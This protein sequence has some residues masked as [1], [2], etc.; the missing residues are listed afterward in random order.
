MKLF[1]YFNYSKIVFIAYLCGMDAAQ[2][3]RRKN[4]FILLRKQNV[5]F[6]VVIFQLMSKLNSP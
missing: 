1:K 4:V 2:R 6:K 3:F 5:L